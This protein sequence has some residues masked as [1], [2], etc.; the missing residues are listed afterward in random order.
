M[1]NKHLKLLEKEDGL[2]YN[3]RNTSVNPQQTKKMHL[4]LLENEFLLINILNSVGLSL[5]S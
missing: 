2:E 3:Q 1:R 4:F 5:Y